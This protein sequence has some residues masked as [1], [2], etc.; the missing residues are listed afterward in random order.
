MTTI[1]TTA[2]KWVKNPNNGEWRVKAQGAKQGDTVIV[3][4][5][6]G[7]E[8]K[9]RLG[10]EWNGTFAVGNLIPEVITPVETD[11]QRLE[12]FTID[13]KKVYNIGCQTQNVDIPTQSGEYFIS[14]G[15]S[16]LSDVFF[17]CLRKESDGNFTK[18]PHYCGFKGFG[19][20][21]EEVIRLWE[22]L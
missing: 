9:V 4:S 21:V 13:G 11:R 16:V 22:R 8:K 3:R 2:A 20:A 12:F 6:A 7:K 1:N 14:F 5:N 10:H 19:V 15:P 18:D 17:V